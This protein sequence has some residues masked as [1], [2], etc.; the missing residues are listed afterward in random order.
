MSN[1]LHNSSSHVFH[2]RE[3][4][5]TAI[6]LPSK[7]QEFL[8]M[9]AE[10]AQTRLDFRK[11]TDHRDYHITLQFLGDTPSGEIGKL[12]KVLRD[13]SSAFQPFSLSISDWGTFG[14]DRAPKVLWKGVSG[15]VEQLHFLQKHIVESTAQLGFQAELR[16]YR[17]HITMARK[18]VG[19]VPEHTRNGIFDLIPGHSSSVK[20]WTV[21][22]FVLYVTR[23][24]QIPMYEVVDTFSFSC[25]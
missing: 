18:F 7:L 4:L 6:R 24:G 1:D 10:F 17:P 19:Q 21:D 20:S 25:K 16:P 3:R 14:L 23:L 9:E 11:W 13:T 12:R 22:G 2:G 5:F 15:D 8:R